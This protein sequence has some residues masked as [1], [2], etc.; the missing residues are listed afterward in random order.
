M[1]A[2]DAR[3]TAQTQSHSINRDTFFFSFFLYISTA[4][5][6]GSAN[7]RWGE[8][9]PSLPLWRGS[10]TSRKRNKKGKCE[11]KGHIL[12]LFV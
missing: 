7:C 10:S 1:E 12:P 2:P 9:G 3:H 11:T 5:G 4:Q 6:A 8:A